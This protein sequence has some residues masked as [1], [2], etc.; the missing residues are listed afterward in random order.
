MHYGMAIDL[1]LCFGCTEC[2]VACKSNN[3]LPNN[4]W[5]NR[6]LTDGGDYP[7][8]AKGTYPQVCMAHYPVG[9]QHCANPACA[10]VCPVGATWR[11][12]KTGIVVQDVD[13][14]IGCRMCMGA[15]PYSART[16]N[17]EEPAYAVDF[18][19]GDFD[20]PK[21]VAGAVEKCT[22]CANRL[23][24]GEEPACM[25]HCPGRARYWGDLDDP[26]SDVSRAIAGRPT[27]RLLE[28]KGTEPSVYYLA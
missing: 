15:C 13:K 19:L 3:N 23:A 7:D 11:D 2:A 24:R 10:K 17:W 8:T 12:E 20:A 21:H 26:G 4:M 22:F 16:F 1:Q 25:E 14:C 28:D 6:V 5:W 18:P 9:C 27:V